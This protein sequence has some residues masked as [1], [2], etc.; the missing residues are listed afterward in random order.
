MPVVGVKGL[1]KITFAIKQTDA[2]EAQPEV[3]RS[4]GVVTCEYSTRMLEDI[5]DV[6]DQMRAGKIDG[7]IVLKMR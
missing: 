3:A 6:F 1:L 2:G 5:N 4:F 7:R